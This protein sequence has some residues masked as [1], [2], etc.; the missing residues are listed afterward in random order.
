MKCNKAKFK[1]YPAPL[2]TFHLP[3][4]KVI[5]GVLEV[6]AKDETDARDKLDRS[7]Y[8]EIEKESDYSFSHLY[9][10]EK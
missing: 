10:V 9:E 3:F 1:V 8:S 5:K 4:V 6:N 2:K 7:I